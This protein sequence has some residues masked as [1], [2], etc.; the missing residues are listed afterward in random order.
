MEEQVEKLIKDYKIELTK[1]EKCKEYLC[2][3]N[4]ISEQNNLIGYFY[5][6]INDLKTLIGEGR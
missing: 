1:L 4:E 2:D 5:N 6:F 3:P